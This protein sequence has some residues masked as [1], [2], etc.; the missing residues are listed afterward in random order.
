MLL[1]FILLAKRKTTSC[2]LSKDMV[3]VAGIAGPGETPSMMDKTRN[4]NT[5]K[6]IAEELMVPV[7][8]V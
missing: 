3:S 2:F 7:V 5:K 6:E 1:T 4:K 8:A